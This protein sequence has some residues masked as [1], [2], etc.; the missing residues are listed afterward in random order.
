M[1]N[2]L[3]IGI[4][5]FGR[6]VELVHFQLMKENP[7]TEIG[8][9][10]DITPQRA[11]LAGK[12]G[13]TTY[14]SLEELLDSPIDAVLIAT[15]HNSHFP[16]AEQALRAGKHV[17]LE[18][19]VG[20]NADEA[21]KLKRIAEQENRVITVFHNRRYDPDFQLVK[22]VIAEGCLGPLM[23]VERRHHSFGSGASFGVKSFYPAWRNEKEFGGGALLDWGVH[24]AD[25]LLQLG[26]GPCS[27]IRA[28]MKPFWNPQGLV[29]DYV[30]AQMVAGNHVQLSLEINFAS[31]AQLPLWVVGG[32]EGTLQ[33][34]S[35]R[36]AVLYEKGKRT[37]EFKLESPRSGAMEIYNTFVDAVRNGG[38]LAVTI[39]ETIETMKLLDQIRKSAAKQEEYHGDLVLGATI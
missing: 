32:R 36:D 2:K 4:V 29:D 12:R 9:V 19:P 7:D 22:Q 10:Y 6:I 21:I 5:G 25:Q 11:H 3:S 14:A 27:Q 28:V 38:K 13:L 30:Q 37:K 24:M 34:L 35:E 33:I 20:L 17:L 31:A 8:G 23:V 18:K 1:T 39:E 15:P 26:L 16:I